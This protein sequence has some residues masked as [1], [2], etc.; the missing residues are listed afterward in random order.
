MLGN[1]NGGILG[2]VASCLFGTNLHDKAAEATEVYVLAMCK[3]ILHDL[4][5]LLDGIQYSALLNA[6]AFG[7]FVNDVG[8]SH[9]FVLF[10]KYDLSCWVANS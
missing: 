8:F 6:G 4:H 9:C 10:R 1:N 2:D 3:R 7:Y 5:K